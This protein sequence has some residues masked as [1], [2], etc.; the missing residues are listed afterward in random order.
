MLVIFGRGLLA[1][2]TKNTKE[3]LL[4]LYSLEDRVLFSNYVFS[5]PCFGIHA[6]LAALILFFSEYFF[7]FFFF[8]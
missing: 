5:V 1:I 4:T 3:S 7:D 6:S 2:A 8:F